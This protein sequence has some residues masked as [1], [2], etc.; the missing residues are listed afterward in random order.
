M[1]DFEN[2]EPMHYWD[3]KATMS[4]EEFLG[5][6]KVLSQ[7]GQYI[8]SEKKDGN[9]SRAII[10]PNGHSLLQSRGISKKTGTYCE[11]QDQVF[12]WEDVKKAFSNTTVILGEV[13]LPGGIDRDVGSI[14]RCLPSKAMARQKTKKLEWR[15]FDV[16]AYEG[17]DLMAEPLSE[18]IKYIPLAVAKINNPLVVGLQYHEMNDTFFDDL[19]N[20]F[21]AGGEGAVC[22][23]KTMIYAPGKRKAWDTIKVKQAI[24]DS[25]DVFVTRYEP[26]IIDYTGTDLQNWEYWMDINTGEK[27]L[28]EY[29]IQYCTNRGMVV[30]PI[31]KGCYNNWPGSVYCGVYN[32]DGKVVE[33]CKVAGLTDE[34][35]DDIRDNFES[36][37]KMR[38]L[39]IGGMMVSETENGISIRHPYIRCLRDDINP[40]DCLL[41]KIIQED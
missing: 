28:G 6:L 11:L 37:W 5:K 1:T 23:K 10:D 30:K 27:L 20:I 41:S 38:C 31:T 16:L 8:W 12:W 25:I 14:L 29:F 33:L 35:R 36:N 18:R 40:S 39:A 2:M 4:R 24:E 9:W 13:Y 15:I 26:S 22:S 17:K 3:S 7:T 21:A 19:N 32:K 34:M